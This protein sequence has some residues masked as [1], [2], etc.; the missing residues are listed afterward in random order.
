MWNHKT[1][2][3][4]KSEFS[5]VIKCKIE[6]KFKE[7]TLLHSNKN[8]GKEEIFWFVYF[9]IINETPTFQQKLNEKKKT[10]KYCKFTALKTSVML[11]ETL[12]PPNAGTW[13]SGKD[14]SVGK[15]GRH[16]RRGGRG[17]DG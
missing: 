7:F 16:R 8:N 13:L 15:D 12:W 3:R 1:M 6:A 2:I 9:V 5:K 10:I 17:W 4:T 14:P 11:R